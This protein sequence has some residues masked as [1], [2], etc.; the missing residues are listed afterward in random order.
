MTTIENQNTDEGI[1]RSVEAE[2]AWT[3]DVDAPGIGV[4]VVDGTVTLS[5]EDDDLGREKSAVRAAFRTAGVRTVVDDLVIHASSYA[6]TSTETDL[7]KKVQKALEWS[8]EVPAVVH[9]T[10]SKHNVELGGAVEWHYQRTAAQRVVAHIRG[11]TSVVN[12]IV[13]TQ[14]AAAI[15]TETAIQA[16]LIRNTALD[17]ASIH[18]SV[19][20]TAATLTGRVRTHDEWQQAQT[21][22]W[23]SPHVESVLNDIEIG[24]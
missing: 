6:W 11:V 7:A 22:A 24:H 20:G 12:N 21:E 4:A 23:S 10:I 13:L 9:A 16:A 8:T 1:R 14:R 17:A 2:L 18:V 19:V 3:P 15:G 5:G